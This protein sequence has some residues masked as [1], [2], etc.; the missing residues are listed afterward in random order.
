MTNKSRILRK[1]RLFGRTASTKFEQLVHWSMKQMRDLPD[2]SKYDLALR[3]YD[4]MQYQDYKLARHYVELVR[5]VYRRD[6]SERQYAATVAVI[7]GI[8]KLML[9]KDEPYVAYLL[10]RYEKKVRD[11]AKFG[12]DESNGDRIVYRHHT[13]PE[14]NVGKFR[15]RLRLTT[16]D[17]QLRLVSKMKWWRKLPGWHRREAEFRDW[18]VELL[19]RVSLAS[20]EDYTKS[21]H[22]LRCWEEVTG[23]REVRYPKQ[24][25]ARAAV[26]A[27]LT[28]KVAAP[29][30]QRDRVMDRI[31][32]PTRA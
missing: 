5:G 12:V 14:F 11:V 21:V 20:D 27:E 6:K 15:V 7:W 1:T 16:T 24:D 25:Q 32:E 9:I 22:L 28:P 26:E 8:S 10:T 3:I 4:L 23:Y 31:A 2:N 13:S 30:E 17:W 18:Y 29:A 19:N